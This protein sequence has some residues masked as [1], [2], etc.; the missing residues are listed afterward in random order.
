[1]TTTLLCPIAVQGDLRAPDVLRYEI[2]SIV[3][4]IQWAI[5]FVDTLPGTCVA[6]D[7]PF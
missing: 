4:D 5:V 1:M 7:M 2:D 6:Y 3:D